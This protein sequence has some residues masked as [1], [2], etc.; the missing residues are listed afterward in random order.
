MNLLTKRILRLQA[1]NDILL[2]SILLS[3]ILAQGSFSLVESFP[4][5]SDRGNILFGLLASLFTLLKFDG[6][7]IGTLV[8]FGESL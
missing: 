2:M 6:E 8:S 1:A 7:V 3:Y 4:K 5:I